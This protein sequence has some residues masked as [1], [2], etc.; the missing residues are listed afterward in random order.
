MIKKL[1]YI[2]TAL[3]CLGTFATATF[4]SSCNGNKKSESEGL[5]S[6]KVS[7]IPLDSA[8]GY[9]IYQDSVPVIEQKI[10]P[11]LPGNVGF[12][13]EQEALKTGELVI[14]KLKKGIFPPS[15]SKQELD[16]LGIVYKL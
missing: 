4:F 13:T 11:G 5:R 9:R 6:Y 3:I 10:I 12:N 16:S 7:A 1:T 2:R 8:W 15:V 14:S